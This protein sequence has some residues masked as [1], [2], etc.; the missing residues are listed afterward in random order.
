MSKVIM[1]PADTRYFT[2]PQNGQQLYGRPAISSEMKA[3]CI[4][5]FSWEEQAD[6]YDENGNVIE[7][8]ATRI[9][10]WDLCKEIYKRMA[11]AAAKE[12]L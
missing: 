12:V 8:V 5:E 7:H 11:Q 1:I 9:V 2:G 3:E 4:G 6:Y 10:P